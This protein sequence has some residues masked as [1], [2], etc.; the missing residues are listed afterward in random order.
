MITTL[1]VTS[2]MFV[3]LIF[4]RFVSHTFLSQLIPTDSTDTRQV[5]FINISG[6]AFNSNKTNGSF[7]INAS[8]YTSHY[9]S[10][11]S[12]SVL[13]IRAVFKT[14]K[15]KMKKPVPSDN[16]YVSVEGVLAKIESDSNGRV[17]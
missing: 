7:E 2:F 3:S 11:K 9:K 16:T 8:Q 14:A 15:Y 6:K 12:L 1:Q 13:P 4:P 17:V 5:A 10:N